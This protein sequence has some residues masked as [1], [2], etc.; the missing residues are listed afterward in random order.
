MYEEAEEEVEDADDLEEFFNDL[1]AEEIKWR[2]SGQNRDTAQDFQMDPKIE[3]IT[4]KSRLTT[5]DCE[6][7]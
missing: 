6:K 1:A 2:W 4:S 5:R 7:R 3:K